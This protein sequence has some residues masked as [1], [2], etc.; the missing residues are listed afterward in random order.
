MERIRIEE[1]EIV[2]V[3]DQQQSPD[4]DVCPA[5]GKGAGVRKVDYGHSSADELGRPMGAKGKDTGATWME[6]DRCGHVTEFYHWPKKSWW[7]VTIEDFYGNY[8]THASSFE[9]EDAVRKA[10][11]SYEEM[12]G[13]EYLGDF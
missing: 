4:H 1:K 8:L 9:K 2:V 5:C 7:V 6:C 10:S 12:S 11:E 13:S 3:I